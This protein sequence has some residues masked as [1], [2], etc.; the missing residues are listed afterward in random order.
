MARREQEKLDL[1]HHAEQQ[2]RERER[3]KNIQ[4]VISS[5]I[6][7]MR[8]ANIPDRFIKDVERNLDAPK[9]LRN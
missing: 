6:S 2:E 1:Q 5:K 9:K 7:T 4:S 8:R 3:Q